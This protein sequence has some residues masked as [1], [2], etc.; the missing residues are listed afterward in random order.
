MTYKLGTDLNAH[1]CL[2]GHEKERPIDFEKATRRGLSWAT[3]R[4]THGKTGHD[5]NFTDTA[6]GAITF[7]WEILQYHWYNPK[8]RTP[9]AQAD[10]FLAHE[11]A[12]FYPMLDCEDSKPYYVGYAGIDLDIRT[13]LERVRDRL[14]KPPALYM[15]LDFYKSYFYD[16]RNP[17]KNA[18]LSEYPLILAQWSS[19]PFPMLSGPDI[20][21][22]WTPLIWRGWQYTAKGPADWY[23]FRWVKDCCLQLLQS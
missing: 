16:Y 15:N 7:Q 22:P 10:N 23:G 14:N 12:D 1:Q 20:P 4:C 2:K 3:L 9:I 18:W 5:L 17:H 21:L 11:A 6:L 8:E 19:P 13:W